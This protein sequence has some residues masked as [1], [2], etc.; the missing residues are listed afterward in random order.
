MRKIFLIIL[1]PNADKDFLLQRIRDLGD[2]YIVFGSS[3]FVSSSYDTAQEVY[4]AII[5]ESGQQ[6]TSVVLD[7]GTNPGYWGY[8]KRELWTWLNSHS[9]DDVR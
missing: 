6:Q 8:T 2:V 1:G 9:S 4:N 7:L 3:I 5:G